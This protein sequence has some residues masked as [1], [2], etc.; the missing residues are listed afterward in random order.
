VFVAKVK[1][2]SSTR[3]AEEVDEEVSLSLET[4]WVI[5]GKITV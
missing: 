3:A 5:I 2:Y 4:T 1:T